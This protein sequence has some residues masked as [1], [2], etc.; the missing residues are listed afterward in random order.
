MT[1]R[2]K[3]I[4]AKEITPM[5]LQS[6]VINIQEDKKPEVQI[7]VKK[8]QSEII[9]IPPSIILSASNSTLPKSSIKIPKLSLTQEQVDQ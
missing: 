4:L 6:E 8:L 1:D 3:P 9:N 2:E 5:K 7:A